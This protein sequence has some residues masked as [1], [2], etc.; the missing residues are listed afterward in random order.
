MGKI[1][2]LVSREE[3]LYQAHNILQEK[4][5]PVREMRV[6]RS[7]S[8]VMEARQSIADGAS[9]IIAR[10]LQASLIKQYTDVPVV[11]IVLTAQ[12]MALLVMKARQIIKSPRPVIAVIGF[13]NM[14]CDMTYFDELY[15]IE[16]RTYFAAQELKGTLQ[17][18]VQQA[19]AEGA[20]LIIG[21]DTVIEAATEAGVP[22]LFLSMTEDSLNNAFSMAER[23]EYAMEVEKKS[24]AQMETL[25]DYTSSGVIRL[26]RGGDVKGVN[27]MMEAIMGRSQEE[28]VGLPIAEIAPEIRESVLEQ[29][30]G[31]GK[32]Y[33]L[34][35]ELNHIS[36][37]A[38]LAPVLYDNEADGAIITC[39]RTARQPAGEARS[40]GNQ[41][42]RGLPPLLRFEDMLQ[43]S[44]SMKAC[45]RLARLYAM[46]G[47]PV[48]IMG[49]PGTEKRMMAQSIHNSS[50]RSAGPFLDVPCDG[51][52]DQEQREMIFGDKGVVMEARG[53][54]LLIQD[55]DCLTAANQYRLYRLIRYRVCHG[56]DMGQMRKAD[57]RVMVTVQTPLAE[58]AGAGRMRRDLYYLLSGLE[59]W[60]PPLRERPEDL[61]QKLDT[62][63]RECCEHYGR[64]HVLTQGARKILLGYPW[65]GNLFQ[66]ESFCD[67][68]ILTAERRSV[69]EIAVKELM[70]ELYGGD[71]GSRGAE[72]GKNG[73][74]AKEEV[75]REAAL[76]A[77]TLKKNGGS[78]EKTAQE[79]GISKTT[80]W[81]KMKK[82]G[83]REMK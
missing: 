51:L 25:L 78:R 1:V 41:K 4:K 24:A 54:T 18:L 63:I 37:F 70:R 58:L 9:I 80:L 52:S 11:E 35:L 43:E 2:L 31:Q 14:F 66:I 6:I 48:V 60:V 38:V 53:G 29:V 44:P 71:P 75:C 26:G 46:S 69:D 62:A 74:E 76:I 30:L 12:E 5:Y 8:A 3:M 57:V 27:G 72:S 55:A 73:K 65:P 28:L 33:S 40:Q 42:N 77:G 45:I 20:E 39:H 16:L 47:Q 13:K 34:F 79:L 61:T 10:G 68:L 36:V 67:R 17:E 49:E 59:L 19:V 22:S 32:E 82:Y 83:V 64:F 81:R 23:M 50:G 56:R 7:E 21:G 15:H